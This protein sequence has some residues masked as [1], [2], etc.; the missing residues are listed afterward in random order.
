MTATKSRVSGTFRSCFA[1]DF[2]GS[3]RHEIFRFS[4]L[5]CVV[6]FVDA[7][8]LPLPTAPVPCLQGGLFV[9]HLNTSSPLFHSSTLHHKMPSNQPGAVNLPRI[10]RRPKRQTNWRCRFDALSA[11]DVLSMKELGTI[12]RELSAAASTMSQRFLLVTGLLALCH[13]KPS[14]TSMKRLF[15]LW[16]LF[17]V[18]FVG[19]LCLLQ[20]TEDDLSEICFTSAENRKIRAFSPPKNC[21]ISDLDDEWAHHCTRFSKEQLLLLKT[22]L[23]APET[24]EFFS[25]SRHCYSA[26]GETVMLVSLAY[27]ATGFYIY[28]L[29]P[30]LF[31]DDPRPWGR[32]ID[33]FYEHIYTTFYHRI[34]GR[35]LE[36]FLPRLLLYRLAMWLR[37]TSQATIQELLFDNNVANITITHVDM[38]M[39]DQRVVGFLDD[40][41]D[42][43]YRPGEEPRRRGETNDDIQRAFYSGYFKTHGL[44]AQTVTFPDGMTGSVF[45]AS[46][47]VNDNGIL[48]LSRLADYL[49][50][51]FPRLANGLHVA[52]YTDGIMQLH[53]CIFGRMRHQNLGDTAVIFQRYN[54]MRIVIEHSYTRLRMFRLFT[55]G[56]KLSLYQRGNRPRELLVSAFLLANCYAIFNGSTCSSIFNLHPPSLDEYLPLDVGFE[57]APTVLIQEENDPYAY[58]IP[59]QL[60]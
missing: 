47:R 45:V 60:N 20:Q 38:P 3:S 55:S 37:L 36:F 13:R 11:E 34:S 18:Q 12:A 21:R 28:E 17:N 46:K 52:L 58:N 24:F 8:G 9:E 10:L 57:S 59:G 56:R 53:Q 15:S 6:S 51:I 27:I 19:L 54:A 32:F 50:S 1:P 33:K 22:H 44:K 16:A 42:D 40:M 4:C 23:R 26:S 2:G 30:L 39:M 14:G 31:G 35:S 48:N 43:Y 49:F 29:V 5:S 25:D 41:D 7:F